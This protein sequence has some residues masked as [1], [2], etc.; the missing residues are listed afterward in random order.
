[1]L[2]LIRWT[3][4]G[5]FRSSVS[6][7]AEILTLRDQLNV[8][9]GNVS[10]QED[11]TFLTGSACVH[12]HGRG[13]GLLTPGTAISYPSWSAEDANRC[14]ASS[15]ASSRRRNNMSCTGHPGPTKILTA[16]R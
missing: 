2:K 16:V 11:R 6:L 12:R 13:S 9:A 14:L 15:G 5:L 7:E 1:M 3:V 10:G 8:L 4:I